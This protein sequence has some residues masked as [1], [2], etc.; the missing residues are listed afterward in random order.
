MT[1]TPSAPSAEEFSER[2]FTSILATQFCQ[3]AFLGDHLGYYRAL[4]SHGPMTSAELGSRSGTA[5]RYA[6]EWL[7]HQAV[8]GVL[9]V[10][11]SSAAP[12]ERKFTLPPGPAEVLTD[13]TSSTHVLPMVDMACGLGGHLDALV[14]AYR[15]GGGVTW[16][17]FGDDV[18]NGQGAAN[19]PLFQGALVNDYLPAIP[20][21]A[22]VLQSG[23]RIADIGC[24]LGWSSVGIAQAYP[25]VTV[26]GYDNDLP[27]I[28]TARANA[29]QAGVADR[30]AFHLADGREV[31][32]AYQLV[33]AFEC[34]HD[35]PDPVSVLS[36]MRL[37]AEPDGIV[38]VM[39]ENVAETFTAPGNA[40]EQF[41][42]GWSVTCCLPDSMA[43]PGS[44]GTGTVMRPDTLRQYAS[45]AGFAAVE[46]LPVE[47]DFFR[48][49]RLR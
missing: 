7:E 39:D 19:R 33:T 10:D 41:M 28:E 18:R 27:S 26:D 16:A 17:E 49:Y 44:V 3:A 5:E 2:L 11:D 36:S 23:G 40:V 20:D 6:R 31:A 35:L 43:H 48:F 46:V 34:I 25:A 4:A 21:I 30:V 9:V 37:L 22:E 1:S 42:Y 24:G 14:D 29:T 45:E 32:G 15:S 8:S 38:L 12:N 47:D 13:V